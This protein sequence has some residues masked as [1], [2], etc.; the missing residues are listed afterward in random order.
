MNQTIN[1]LREIK[2]V[3]SLT[4]SRDEE[5]IKEQYKKDLLVAKFTNFN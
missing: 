2:R 3:D 1:D 5:L 4:V